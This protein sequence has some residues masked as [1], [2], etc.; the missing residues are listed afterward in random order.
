MMMSIAFLSWVV[1]T[2]FILMKIMSSNSDHHDWDNSAV[3]DDE[4]SSSA[5]YGLFLPIVLFLRKRA[6]LHAPVFLDAG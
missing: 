2:V 4:K 5:K 6:F 1:R 3:H